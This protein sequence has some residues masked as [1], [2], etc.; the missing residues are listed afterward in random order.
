MSKNPAQIE[1]FDL[2]LNKCYDTEQKKSSYSLQI[3]C[4]ILTK[5]EV[6]CPSNFIAYKIP[7]CIV[8]D[9]NFFTVTNGEENPIVVK[10]SNLTT[11]VNDELAIISFIKKNYFISIKTSKCQKKNEICIKKIHIP[12]EPSC[13]KKCFIGQQVPYGT[14][15]QFVCTINFFLLQE[16]IIEVFGDIDQYSL[17]NL[18]SRYDDLKQLLVIDF[19]GGNLICAKE[20]LINFT[21][22]VIAIIENQKTEEDANEED[23]L[24]SRADFE[25]MLLEVEASSNVSALEALECYKLLLATNP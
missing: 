21:N 17:S 11:G 4:P 10:Y 23:G 8:I 18:I 13:I 12:V 14:I 7:E 6:E 1:T 9:G 25:A 5:L 16:C 20:D 3:C 24:I 2:T 22:N 15:G 19:D